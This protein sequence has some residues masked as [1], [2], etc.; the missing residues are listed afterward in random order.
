MNI[1]W[2][3]DNKSRG[4]PKT[5][6]KT[7]RL[8]NGFLNRA[9]RENLLSRTQGRKRGLWAQGWNIGQAL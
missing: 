5:T 2:V 4:S 3:C 6:F 7:A 8:V 1:T 9:F